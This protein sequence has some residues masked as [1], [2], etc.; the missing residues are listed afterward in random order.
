LQN[1]ER[2]SVRQAHHGVAHTGRS[3]KILAIGIQTIQDE[4]IAQTY[5]LE[6]RLTGVAQLRAQ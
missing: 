6:N 3:F 5:H 4:K 2:R 1:A